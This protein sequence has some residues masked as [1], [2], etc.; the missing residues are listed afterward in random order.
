MPAVMRHGI[1][2]SQMKSGAEKITGA[3]NKLLGETSRCFPI[4]LVARA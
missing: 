3:I 4:A 1:S 2:D